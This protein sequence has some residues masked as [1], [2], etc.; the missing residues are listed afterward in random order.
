MGS[1]CCE[2]N[3]ISGEACAASWQ[4]VGGPAVAAESVLSQVSFG[5]FWPLLPPPLT[6]QFCGDSARSCGRLG[7]LQHLAGLL[8]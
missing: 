4:G 3:E 7:P 6:R 8:I 1:C 5:V 2:K